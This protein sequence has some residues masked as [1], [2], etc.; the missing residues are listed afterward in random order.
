M[1]NRRSRNVGASEKSS[2]AGR[3]CQVEFELSQITFAA[4]LILLPAM[5]PF[6]ATAQLCDKPSEFPS[7]RHEWQIMAGYSPASVA[8]Y[9]T[10]EERRFLL[11][12]ARYSYRCKVWGHTTL[13]YTP[14]IFPAAILFQPRQTFTE[15]QDG[16]LVRRTLPSHAVYGIA[17]AP[18]GVTVHFARRRRVQPLIESLLGIHAAT[19][20][21]PQRG[22]DATGLNFVLSFGAGISWRFRD[23]RAVEF[24]Y[25]FFHISNASTTSFNPGVDNNVIYAGY[26]FLR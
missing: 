14:A 12:G 11:V 8:G 3:V 2:P 24:G 5:A 18:L 21:I 7:G 4:V 10:T 6:I 19:E 9:G 15:F 17:A 1:P 25:K 26:S 13:S 23:D 16:R 22:V 20:P